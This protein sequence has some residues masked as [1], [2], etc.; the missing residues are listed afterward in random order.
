MNKFLQKVAK[1]FLGLS[2]AAGVGVAVGTKDSKTTVA[3]ATAVTSGTQGSLTFSTNHKV[4]SNGNTIS[5][6]AGA[7]WTFNT[8]ASN[9]TL[10]SSAIQ[11]GSNSVACSY[12][13]WTTSDYSSVTISSI[14][15]G[16]ASTNS[17]ASATVSINGTN[18]GDAQA[19]SSTAS[20][21]T[22]T[23]TNSLKGEVI[24]TLSR[25]SSAK[26]NIKITSL[27]I[28]Y[29]AGNKTA[30]TT[31]LGAGST[32]ISV[33]GTTTLSATVS[34]TG[35]TIS[36]PSVTYTTEDTSVISISG[37]TVTG[38][39]DGT[40]TI[41]GSY[42]GDST[43]ASSKGTIEI[44]VA[45][46]P[47]SGTFSLYSGDISEGDYIIYYDGYA[48][49]NTISSSRFTYTGV[50]PVN[51][52]ITNPSSNIVWH[53][54]ANGE[55]WTIQSYSSN[56]YAGSTGSKNQ[57]ALLDSVTDNAKWTVTGS[58]TFEFENLARS[59]GTDS[60]NKWL[61]NNGTSG[62]ACYSTS[63]GGALTLYKIVAKYSVTYVHGTNGTGDDYVVSNIDGG[64]D[65]N[66]VS[67]ATS[68]FS[69]NEG[70]LFKEW[71]VGGVGK[72][73]GTSITVNANTT[74]TAIYDVKRTVSYD[75]NGS[76]G[77]TTPSTQEVVNGGT[78][79]AA[80]NTFTKTDHVFIGW[81]TS[82][83]GQG[84]SYAAGASVTVSGGNIILYA[85][86]GKYNK[87]TYVAGA[88]GSGAD[89]VVN[90]Q[91]SGSYTLLS[92][93]ATGLTADS[94]YGFKN[95]SVGGQVKAEGAS[96]TISDDTTVTAIFDVL[97]TVSY[98][99]NGG[100][101][102][103]PT[104]QTVVNG[105][106]VNAADN[107]FSYTGH[108][109]SGW[110]TSD[111]GTGISY[112]AG[113][114]VTVSGNNVTLYAQWVEVI[115]VTYLGN[116]NT[117]GSVPVDGN[118]YDENDEV[119]VLSN[120]GSLVKSDGYE[121]YGW[122]TKSDGTGTFYAPGATFNIS[123]A[124]NLYAQWIKPVS[125]AF[126]FTYGTDH[127]DT[128]ELS[129]TVSG[130]TVS[131]TVGDGT[132]ASN[133]NNAYKTFKGKDITIS[134]SKPIAK[135]IFTCAAS[136]TSQYGPG[137]YTLKSGNGIYSYSG[138]L[139]TWIGYSS[140][141]VLNASSNQVR[142]TLV[143]IY[144]AD[145]PAITVTGDSSVKAGSSITLTS[146]VEGVSWTSSDDS[147]A[148]VASASSTTA[149]VTGVVYSS[150][151][152]T[153]TA[154]KSGYESCV[155]T[156]S[157]NYADVTSVSISTSTPEMGMDS[158][159]TFGAT[160][161]PS[162][163][164]PNVTWSV[165]YKSGDISTGYSIDSN[166]KLTVNA[167]AGGVLTVTATTV[168]T[169]SSSASKIAT[170]DVTI[171]GAPVV[172][173]ADTLS[174]YSGKN[175]SLAYSF[176]NFTGTLSVESGDTSK[177]TVGTPSVTT[178]TSGSGTVQ[179]NFIAATNGTTLTFKNGS[180]NVATC[181]VTVTAS[182]VSSVTWSVVPTDMTLY[183]GS[184][185]LNAERISEWAPQ[186][187][188]NNGDSGSISTNYT[189][190][191]NGSAYALGSPLVAG[192]YTL[193]LSYGG[194]T[195]SVNNPTITVVQSLNAISSKLTYSYAASSGAIPAT[196]SGTVTLGGVQWSFTR[197]NLYTGFTSS[198]IQLGKSSNPEDVV[199]STTGISG[200]VSKISVECSSKSGA[201]TL[202]ATV[203]GTPYINAQN[204]ASWTTVDTLTGTGSSSGEIVLSFAKGDAALYI[205]SIE[206]EY[207]GNLA[208]NTAHLEAQAKVVE[209]AQ[210]LNSQMNGNK[211]C[212]GDMSNLGTAWGNVSDKY[213]ALFGAD[214]SLSETELAY[215]KSMLANASAN[216]NSEHDSDEQYCLERAMKTYDWCVS[217]YAGT[218]TA[219]MSA[220]R[221]V[222]APRVSL[223][224]NIIGE[225]TN[226]VAIIVI[227]S[228][229][230][231]TA[232]GGY[233]FLRKRKENN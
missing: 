222:E 189:I 71:S 18:L 19:L 217:H 13:R 132:F 199:L 233:F 21:Y 32:S 229:V 142:Y 8:D 100:T 50:T 223:L 112:A 205:K 67:F 79:T 146:D 174:G 89:Y 36:S 157:V 196:E 77:G 183:S 232:I 209:F 137:C 104:S 119:T 226:T 53:I 121:F 43:Y 96:I 221:T 131:L 75:G 214:S 148:T 126:T 47:Y 158:F 155:K 153:V 35:G 62:F 164:N 115:N 92:F 190:E 2:M 191:L 197:D 159:F 25:D 70:Y 3:N 68:G 78:V 192:T 31:V 202:T 111:D 163:A 60:G 134:S 188:M 110:N 102:T 33:G 201:H 172:A 219:F 175:A 20:N 106:S 85:Q 38:L 161:L 215:A 88:N 165:D 194:Q 94:G 179:V 69:A 139:G 49:K 207:Q 12:Q 105:G 211:V 22:F 65:H 91:P 109:F 204:T 103:A 216:W 203:G 63:T 227:I 160:V 169:D 72:Q 87:V 7:T 108:T 220:V 120:S 55:Y 98:D 15:V 212:T 181:T 166:G 176:S 30:T 107:T 185:A 208:N 54:A 52:T 1:I 224:M 231:V 133:G 144:F 200:V 84:T 14:V 186:Y 11:T 140:E 82:A 83:N 145:L 143:Q 95:W 23:N 16:G 149:T 130:N 177:V 27:T 147:I 117:G 182:A 156:I 128:L 123:A 167:D 5:D 44:T 198:C 124:T 66:L 210:Y 225:N 168:G 113:A 184:T 41:T 40:A 48:M 152:I 29:S 218:C 59:T 34:Y 213:T 9:A 228:M 93:G 56:K 162:T 178:G 171:T 129:K 138:T 136:G 74:V 114:P 193:T 90:D 37:N 57:G 81:N 80:S 97:R 122:N 180:D 173:V 99:A 17:S 101:G 24:V 46:A 26:K 118:T 10:Q 42:E 151:S 195:T 6:D 150:S 170:F 116:G 141:V 135:V 39:A 154:S 125:D 61:R 86:W 64:S 45:A 127:S 76:T 4:S 73:P 230:S 206:I 28:N 187:E 58:S 51:N